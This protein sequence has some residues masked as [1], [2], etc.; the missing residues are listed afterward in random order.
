MGSRKHT[1]VGDLFRGGGTGIYSLWVEEVD[2]KTPHGT[3]PGGLT[4]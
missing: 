1:G 2:D 3:G 4:E